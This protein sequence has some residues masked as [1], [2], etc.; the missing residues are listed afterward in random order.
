MNFSKHFSSII[1]FIALAFSVFLLLAPM[2]LGIAPKVLPAAAVVLLAVA[3]WSTAVVSSALGS[4]I[5]LFAAVVLSV[6]PASIVFSGFYAGA[7]W[8]VFGG[9]VVGLGVRRSGLDVRLINT[10]LKRLPSSYLGIV[11]GIFFV[12]FMLAWVVPS[13]SARVALLVPIVLSLNKR[14]G[15]EVGSKG[16]NGLV[17]A[18]AMGT[19]TPAFGI[20]PSNV[21][22][23]ALFGAI[24]S[25]HGIRI[26]YAEYLFL[27]FPVIGIGAVLIYPLVIFV[28]F[29]DQP[30]PAVGSEVTKSWSIDE[31]KLLIIV[32][33]ALFLWLTDTL[34]GVSPAWVALGAAL[35]CLL[36]KLGLLP[37]KTLSK[38]MDYGPVL[39]V[40]GVIGLGAVATHSGLGKLIA[41]SIL[42]VVPLE[43]GADGTNFSMIV[44]IGTV[45]GIFT[46]MPAQPSIMVPMA[47]AMASASGWPLMSI[48]MAPVVTWI[49]FPFFYQA[50][51][52]VLAV[53]LGELKIWWVIRMLLVYMIMSIIILL[54]IHFL[55]GQSLGYFVSG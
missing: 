31:K 14:L 44:L 45:V 51:P 55:W 33:G 24:E 35:I 13:A 23:M 39:F 7:T 32:M 52:V 30:K 11:Y 43:P 48:L 42:E 8:L 50:P 6:A 46:T 37:P 47:S 53:A 3:L 21:P 29:K 20:L 54:P 12:A 5:F 17:L 10:L 38:E 15:F 40:A 19:M 1:F 4:I 34:H 41:T 9:L 36:P 2:P 25:I 16:H 18:S 49:M 28:L 26:A 22:N 27:N